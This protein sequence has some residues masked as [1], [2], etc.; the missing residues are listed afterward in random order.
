MSENA[1]EEVDLQTLAPLEERIMAFVDE[2]ATFSVQDL[3][4]IFP[5]EPDKNLYRAV[6]RLEKNG[7]IR[8]L[9]HQSKRKI[10]TTADVTKLPTIKV[11]TERRTIKDLFDNIDVVYPDGKYSM[12]QS[13][14]TLPLAYAKLF[15]VASIEDIKERKTAFLL[16]HKEMLKHRSNLLLMLENLD[17]VI[18]HPIMS[19]DLEYFTAV[20]TSNEGPNPP[21]ITAFKAWYRRFMEEGND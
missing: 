17:S 14:N 12:A 18:Q 1:F 10:Y 16:L 3:K 2:K 6:N 8:F 15:L 11:G 9:K 21:D 7:A 13:L 5:T 20:L 19:G 4:E